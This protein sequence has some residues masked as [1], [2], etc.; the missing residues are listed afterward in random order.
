MTLDSE[1]QTPLVEVRHLAKI[2]PKRDSILARLPGRGKKPKGSAVRAV[3][4]VS[5]TIGHNET[6]AVVGESGS[7]KTTLGM[8]ILRLTEPTSGNLFFMGEEITNLKG[9]KMRK[10]RSSMQIVFQDPSSSLDPRKRVV[11]SIAE[12]LRASGVRDHATVRS[13]VAEVLEAVGLSSSQMRQLPHQF[14]GGQR[15]RIGIA[16]AIVQKP[17][18][19]VLDEPTSSLDASVQAQILTLLLKLQSELN[20]SYLLITHNIAVARYMSDGIA[21]MYRGKIMEIGKTSEVIQFPKHP[22]TKALISSVLEPDISAEKKVASKEG[23]K[24]DFVSHE[25][26]VGCYYRDRCKYAKQ[27]CAEEKPKLRP[28]GNSVEVACHFAEEIAA[29]EKTSTS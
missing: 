3:D 8:C 17:R 24:E 22:Y 23:E 9:E 12:P 11:D 26:S 18:F 13:R 5:F 2:F 14:S 27:R 16:R 4:D 10:L 7:G 1:K 19:I 20:L 6:F 28:F 29:T 25:F 21:V 15:Q